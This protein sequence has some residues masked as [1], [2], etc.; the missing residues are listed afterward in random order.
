MADALKLPADTAL[1]HTPALLRE[2]DAALDAAA[3]GAT[4]QIDASALT[5][6]DTSTIALL[7]HARRG[8]TAR[9]LTLQV[10]GTPPKLRELALL[11]G[12]EE[13]LP[14]GDAPA[15]T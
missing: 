11:Y 3:S 6:F 4:L 5:A 7:L 14:L 12:V 1:E 15:A 13:L 9:G 10:R 2:V 8:A